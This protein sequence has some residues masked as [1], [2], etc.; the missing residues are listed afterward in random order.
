[1]GGSRACMRGWLRVWT[2]ELFVRLLSFMGFV[3]CLVFYK[4]IGHGEA[5]A[6]KRKRK[7]KRDRKFILYFEEFLFYGRV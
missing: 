3:M 5:T 4:A 2:M 6:I 7:R 1:M